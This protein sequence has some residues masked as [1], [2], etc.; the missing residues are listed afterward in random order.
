[1][2]R[3]V[4]SIADK[5]LKSPVQRIVRDAEGVHIT[6]HGQTERFDKVV[7]AC[8]SDE[9]LALLDQPSAQERTV[10]ASI[11]YQPNRAVLHTDTGVLPAKR[12]AWAAWNYERSADASSD[13]TRVCL[14]YLLNLLQPLPFTQSVV[15]SLNPLREIAPSQVLG[16]F[17]YAHPV[18]DVAAI[19]AQRRVPSLQG[20]Q[21]TYYCGAWTGY[22][23]HEDGL[24]SGLNVAR[25]ITMEAL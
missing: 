16:S 1:V 17:D 14:H 12:L 8:H 21:H 25:R 6:T 22:G 15:V 23:F 2:E 3:I 24:K 19:E 13:A 20:Q 11:R 18:F 4:A 7:M 5:R 9:S 10:L